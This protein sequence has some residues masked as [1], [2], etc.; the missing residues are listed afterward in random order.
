MHPWIYRGEI[1]RFEGAPEAGGPVTVADGAGAF[2][3]RGFYN[4]RTSLACRILT[5]RDE[6]IDAAWFAGRIGEAVAYRRSRGLAG[7]AHRLVWSEGDGLPG[8]VV[9]RYSDVVVVQCLTLGM[10]GALP[11]IVAG[12]RAALGDLAIYVSDDPA[13]ARMEGFEPRRAWLGRA[14]PDTVTVREGSAR[15]VVR[16]GE[17]H[18]SGFYLDQAENR[19]GVARWAAGRAVLDAFSYTGAFAVHT[20]AA[21]AE[22]AVCVESSPEALAGAAANLEL[23]GLAGRAELREANAFDELRRLEREHARFGL[24]ILDPPPFTRRKAAVDAATRG[25]KEINLRAM[26]LLERGGILATFSCS[27]HVS[28]ALFEDVCR[29][30]A[31]DAGITMRTLEALTQSRDHPVLLTVPETLYLKGLLV[32]RL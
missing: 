30:A 29:A 9:D 23:N 31:E 2:V 19:L 6:K 17:G 16:F 8:L 18:K 12:I 15:F 5:R 3:G 1:A 27:H 7:E 14:G 4:P 13:A 11:W 22:R 20:L 25:Y 24:V 26:R 28:G 21:G 32:E 10:S